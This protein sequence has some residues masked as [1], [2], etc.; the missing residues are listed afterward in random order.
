M[1]ASTV[2]NGIACLRKGNQHRRPSQKSGTC[3]ENKKAPD[4][5]D[6]FPLSLMIGDD[7]RIP[8]FIS[9]ENLG[10]SQDIEILNVA[11]D[12]TDLICF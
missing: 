3:L 5:P 7:Y 6:S 8:V 1:M 9:R 12:Q 2:K 4:F 11:N 10:R